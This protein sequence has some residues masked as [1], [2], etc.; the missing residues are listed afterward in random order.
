MTLTTPLQ[1]S[2]G[3]IGI[4]A[5]LAIIIAGLVLVAPNRSVEAV[6]IELPSE[7][8][9]EIDEDGGPTQTLRLGTLDLGNGH[10]VVSGRLGGEG[11]DP[12]IPVIGSLEILPAPVRLY[13][14][15]SLAFPS[16]GGDTGGG[17]IA[18]TEI[19]ASTRSGPIESFGVEY[20]PG[21]RTCQTDCA[22]PLKGDRIR[23]IF[24][25]P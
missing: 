10:F 2:L 5:I 12:P 15:L 25:C 24:P 6:M 16:S 4:L 14:T 3:G 1:R 19:L 23:L 20:D 21:T 9:F 22:P 11:G 13:M 18:T 17:Y 8:C 7:L